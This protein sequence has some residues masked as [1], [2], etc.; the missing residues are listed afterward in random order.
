MAQNATIY[1]SS[2]PTAFFYKSI[3]YSVH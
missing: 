2:A 1:V 3:L